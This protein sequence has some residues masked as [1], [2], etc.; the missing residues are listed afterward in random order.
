MK[1]N[2]FTYVSIVRIAIQ[3]LAEVSR[4][5]YL[6]LPRARDDVPTTYTDLHLHRYTPPPTSGRASGVAGEAAE[7]GAA[8]ET[9]RPRRGIGPDVAN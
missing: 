7:G 6:H 2:I 1:N 3:G 9:W 5:I 4:S 8:P